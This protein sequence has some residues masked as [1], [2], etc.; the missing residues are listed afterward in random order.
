MELLNMRTNKMSSEM[1][2][3]ISVILFLLSI[4]IFVQS[5]FCGVVRSIFTNNKR[6]AQINLQMGRSTV[7]HF[8]EKPKKVV[9]GNANYF[10]IEFTERDV[11]IQPLGP[12][13]SNLFVY[14]D[15]HRFGFILRV[16]KF[17]RYDDLV[18][19][20][21]QSTRRWFKGKSNKKIQNNVEKEI[22]CDVSKIAKIQILK[23]Q[24]DIKREIHMFSFL[25]LVD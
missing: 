21:W 4:A 16:G 10:N 17:R 25:V 13:A 18:D 2:G 23:V 8:I 6:M 9:C 5:A 20:K 19:V 7:L 24:K 11:T 15:Y 3:R 22:E 12:V 1:I 14:T